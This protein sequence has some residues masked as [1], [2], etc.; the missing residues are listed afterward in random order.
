M[1]PR[2]SA[3]RA[4]KSGLS[5]ALSGTVKLASGKY[6]GNDYLQEENYNNN[7]NRSRS[8]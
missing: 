5:T 8:K 4:A 2:R 7:V 1:S 3:T 6:N